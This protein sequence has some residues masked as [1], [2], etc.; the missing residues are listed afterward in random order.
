MIIAVEGIDGAGKTSVAKKLS[1]KLRFTYIE[2]AIRSAFSIN[3]DVYISLRES[4]K[5][6]TKEN[7]DV[8]AIF[9]LLNNVICN[10]SAENI[11]AD[12]Y[13]MTNYFFYGNEKNKPLYTAFLETMGKPDYTVVLTADKDTLIKRIRSRGLSKEDEEKELRKV[14]QKI[15]FEDKVVP[16]LEENNL[17]YIVVNTSNLSADEAT[18]IILNNMDI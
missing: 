5:A 11:I 9:F 14:N 7:P 15:L 8:M 17:K 13:L 6:Y 4:L 1:E 16:F 10:V 18:N 2:K 12:R 3:K